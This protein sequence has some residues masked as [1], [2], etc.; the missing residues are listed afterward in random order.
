MEAGDKDVMANHRDHRDHTQPL[1]G[2]STYGGF[3]PLLVKMWTLLLL[4]RLSLP[5]C[6]LTTPEAIT[7]TYPP[8][9]PGGTEWRGGGVEV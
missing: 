7:V 4:V 2:A 9:A 1:A 8:L 6:P 3:G 5:H